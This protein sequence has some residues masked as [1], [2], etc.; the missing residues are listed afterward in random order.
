MLLRDKIVG[1][2]E[3][4]S[5]YFKQVNFTLIIKSI[6]VLVSLVYV[7]MVL[8][9]L[10]QEK[11]GIWVTL[12]T[13]VNWVRLADVGIGGGMRLKLSESIALND[14]EKGHIHV[15]TTYGIIGGIFLFILF[16][17]YIVNPH[18]NWQSIL[19]TSLIP[20]S[21]LITLTAITISLFIIGFILR[22]I[23]QVYLAYG[24]S[25]AESL[26]H[27]I[28]SLITLGLI[29]IAS[30]VSEK[31]NLILLSAIVT[32]VPV[33]IYSLVTIYTFLYKFPH[34][35]PSVKFIKLRESR[36]LMIQSLQSF[37][38]SVTYLVIYGSIPFIVAHLFSPNEVAVFNI[39]YSMFNLPIMVITLIVMP[40]KPLVTIAFTKR[41]FDWIRMMQK[42]L[43]KIAI[44]IVGGTVLMILSNQ[45]IYH[46]WIGDK[47]TIPYILSLSIGFFAI[48][49]ILQFSNSII[50]LGTGKM[51][52]NVILSP[53]NIG[54]FITLSVILSELLNNVIGV[55]I[56]LTVT[57]MIP[58]IVY[59]F[60]L[61]RVMPGHQE[62]SLSR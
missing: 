40:V 59:P 55:S 58:L 6:S 30:E 2:H 61:K 23:N 60:W 11:Y 35:R 16:L 10:D 51:I 56:A 22:T 39:A 52:I 38:S 24:N 46:I 29:W 37:I 45:F 13:V 44:I 53:I 17:F 31:G 15:S 36:S 41:D 28:I 25:T 47:V 57:C 32:G 8:G 43:N 1:S 26:F 21:E 20:N 18:L 19:N 62:G 5:V 48:I 34:L 3:L 27:L 12:T 7:P 33:F 50:V 49:N 4:S 54:I 9:Y 42:K 14:N